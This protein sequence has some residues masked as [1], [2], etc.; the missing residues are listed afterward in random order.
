MDT[1]RS[2]WEPVRRSPWIM[3]VAVEQSPA[4]SGAESDT[5]GSSTESEQVNVML[6]SKMPSYSQK[7]DKTLYHIILFIY[8]IILL[9]LFKIYILYYAAS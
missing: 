3:R 2:Q 7:A 8:I 1:Q 9:V 6:P 5:E 4:S